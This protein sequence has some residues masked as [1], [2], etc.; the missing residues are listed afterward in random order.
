MAAQLMATKGLVL[1][2]R[3]LVDGA[4]DQ[5]LAGAAFA[6]DENRGGAGGDQL[7]EAEDLLHFGRGAD[8]GAELSAVAQLAAG[9]FQ[10]A[11]GAALAGGVLQDIAQAG[12]IDR[13]FDEVVGARSSWRRRRHRPSPGR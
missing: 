7:D 12:G 9:G 6:G 5:L 3:E 8:Q 13:L 10:F 1:A 11:L 2:R 4:G